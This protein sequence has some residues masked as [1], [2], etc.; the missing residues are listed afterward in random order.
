MPTASEASEAVPE[1]V[2]QMVQDTQVCLSAHI[3]KLAPRKG[4]VLDSSSIISLIKSG[5]VPPLVVSS[6]KGGGF[7]L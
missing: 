7:K 2:V 4:G 1:E 3:A 5:L 6:Y